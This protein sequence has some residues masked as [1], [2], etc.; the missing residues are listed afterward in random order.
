M[1]VKIS[2]TR[3]NTLRREKGQL[4]SKKKKMLARR[5]RSLKYKRSVLS[6]RAEL[7]MLIRTGAHKQLY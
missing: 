1:L 3:Q 5:F 6:V 7:Y 2:K 4:E